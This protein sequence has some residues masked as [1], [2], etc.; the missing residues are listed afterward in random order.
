MLKLEKYVLGEILPSTLA[1]LVIFTLIFLLDKLFAMAN[2]VI[3]KG[4]SVFLVLQILLLSVP[5]IVSITFPMALLLGNILGFSRLADDNEI[6]AMLTSGIRYSRIY[7]GSV[8]FSL[9]LSFGLVFYNFEAAP[10]IE[11]RFNTLYTEILRKNPGVILRENIVQEIKDSKIFIKKVDY[12]NFTLE[13]IAVFKTKPGTMPAV[14]LAPAGRYRLDSA[15]TL[16]LQLTGGNVF[17]FD[18]ARQDIFSVIS[19]RNFNA[20]YSLSTGKISSG[21]EDK[22]FSSLTRKGLLELKEKY[23]E[24]PEFLARIQVQYN[25]RISIAFSALILSMIAIPLGTQIK[26]KS[27]AMAFAV[28]LLSIFAY[29]LILSFCISGAERRIISP[30]AAAWTP[31]IIFF[32]GAILLAWRKKLI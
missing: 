14:I 5:A 16:K 18:I 2:L 12:K 19:F 7:A 21:E 26:K 13:K 9:L 23:R 28:S 29:F 15:D 6:T 10:R 20:I 27:K 11:T 25:L 22:P 32:V 24:Y 1:G 30:Q 4:V 8:V 3:I 17:N 31:N